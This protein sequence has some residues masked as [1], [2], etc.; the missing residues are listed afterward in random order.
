MFRKTY[1]NVKKSIDDWLRKV[2]T[3]EISVNELKK[4]K[5]IR[6][7]SRSYLRDL[8]NPIVK[9]STGDYSKPLSDVSSLP[10]FEIE[11]S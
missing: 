10:S 8:K 7:F 2:N 5:S 11:N 9:S 1:V 4:Y 3:M 6:G